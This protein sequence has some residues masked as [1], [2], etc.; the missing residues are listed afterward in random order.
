MNFFRN[1]APIAVEALQKLRFFTQMYWLESGSNLSMLLQIPQLRPS[2]ITIT[3]RY[4]DWWNWEDDQPLS[5]NEQWLRSFNGSPGLRELRV[6]YETRVP[7]KDE[8]M[9]IVERNRKWKLPVRREGGGPRKWEGYL[10]AENTKLNEWTWKGTSK[11]G[12]QQWAHLAKSD[13][14]EYAVVTDVWKFVEGELS[15][16]ELSRHDISQSDLEENDFD[17]F[18]YEEDY[19]TDEEMNEDEDDEEDDEDVSEYEEEDSDGEVS[20][21]APGACE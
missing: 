21:G 1:L 16:E 17:G 10:T 15:Q 11:L 3:I 12:G 9:R 5:M 18:D 2:Q 13:T 6:E 4:S 7:K 20:N 8:M 14:I 19:Y